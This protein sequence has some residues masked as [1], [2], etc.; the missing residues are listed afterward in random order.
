VAAIAM[1]SSLSVGTIG[2]EEVF[3]GRSAKERLN[4]MT[5]HCPIATLDWDHWL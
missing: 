1:A 4:A 2:T 3:T 5:S